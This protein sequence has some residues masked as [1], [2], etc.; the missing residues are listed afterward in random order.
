MVHPSWAW[1]TKATVQA[2]V[3]AP[4]HAGCPTGSL[5]SCHGTAA[6]VRVKRLLPAVG[7]HRQHRPGTHRIGAHTLAPAVCA[8]TEAVVAHCAHSPV[9]QSADGGQKVSSSPP[10]WA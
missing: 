3:C 6:I 9:L 1:L 2:A 10:A 4:L 7:K 5:I 8:F